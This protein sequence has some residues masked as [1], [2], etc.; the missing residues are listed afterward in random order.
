MRRSAGFRERHRFSVTEKLTSA[1]G[2]QLKPIRRFDGPNDVPPNGHADAGAVPIVHRPIHGG[3][4]PN[5]DNPRPRRNL[6]Q[7]LDPDAR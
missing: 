5:C 1:N 3:S 6:A 2:L 7:A 4:H